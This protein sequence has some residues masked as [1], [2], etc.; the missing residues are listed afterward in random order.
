MVVAERGDPGSAQFREQ[1]QSRDRQHG[2]RSR[3]QPGTAPLRGT[4]SGNLGEQFFP[5]RGGRLFS[6]IQHHVE[7]A[8]EPALVGL[9]WSDEAAGVEHV[10]RALDPHG[11]A[12]EKISRQQ[13]L[14][15]EKE[16]LC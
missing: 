10:E 9:L 8:E 5:L 15:Q 16:P 14:T 13:V 6:C 3:G 4:G 2:Q 1:R 7:P 11:L 12:P